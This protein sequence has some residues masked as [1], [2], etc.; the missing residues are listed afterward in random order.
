MA[1]ATA[2]KKAPKAEKAYVYSWEGADKHGK[3]VKGESRAP[4]I[5]LIRADLRRQG[6]N[7]LKVKKKAT[8][9]LNT[10]KKITAGDIA[11]FA[12]QLSTMMEAGVPL[13]QAFDIVGKGHNN[14]S[15][16]DLLLAIKADVEGGTALAE[17]LA[18][19]PLYFDDLFCNL[20]R[21]GEAAGVLE[22]LL[23]KIATYKEKTESIKGKIKK[24]LFYPAAVIIVAILVT[25]LI[26]IFVIPQFQ[27]L[28]ASFGGDLPAFTKMV[29]SL[30]EWMTS[31]WWLLLLGTFAA[32]YF[33]G[34]S[35][36]R[37]RKM[38]EILDKT[39]LQ[40]PII[41]SI[42]HK[43][44]IARFSRTLATMFAAGVPLVEALE[45]V[46]GATGN[47]IY[48][49]AVL[50]MREDIAT[51]QSLQL[52]MKQQQLFPHMV[53]Q[54]VAIGEESGSLDHMLSKVADFY[55]EEVDNAVDALSSL[56][57][58]MIMVVIGTLVGGLVVAM[59]L[60]IFKMASV[61]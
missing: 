52:T 43:A 20:V 40:F 18:K 26:M 10:K 3:R 14:P 8:A 49:N 11:I 36:K 7:P 34:Y 17:A 24:A 46:A 9:L 61:V 16:Q 58:P 15:M 55:E 39:L 57:E 35:Y 12:R 5:A 41:G 32:V 2:A 30:S 23:D 45:S 4:S 54:M 48:S 33:F 25:V 37:S 60:P 47:I 28:F 29:I 56:M 1:T 51:G 21:A 13:V 42:I 31:Y 50:R 38:R 22:N 44:T 6:I 27:S 53:I 19:H 59:Y